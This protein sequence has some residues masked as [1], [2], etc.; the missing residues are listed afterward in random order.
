MIKI[1]I[2]D[3]IELFDVK[4]KELKNDIT[5]IIGIVGEDLGAALFEKYYKEILNIDVIVS[6]NYSPL[7]IT[8]NRKGPRLDRWIY[9]ED[10]K[11]AYQTEIK[12]WSAYAIGGRSISPEDNIKDIALKNWKERIKSIK[13]NKLNRENKVLCKMKRP[14][15][16]PFN[17]FRPE[18]LI[19]YWMVLSKDGK[20]LQ[21]F[22]K[23]NIKKNGFNKLNVFSMSNYLRYLQSKKIKELKLHMPDAE[24]RIN[25]L[26]DCFFLSGVQKK[27]KKGNYGDYEKYRQRVSKQRN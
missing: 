13:E 18:P 19:I 22:F 26:K 1:K 15:D 16:F 5:S 20:N 9:V 7:S 27:H 2:A 4:K 12:N 3:I 25:L 10:S 8:T 14:D 6:K 21:P 23:V 17:K 24:N 11:I